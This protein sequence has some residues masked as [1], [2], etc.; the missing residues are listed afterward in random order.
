MLSGFLLVRLFFS[1]YNVCNDGDAMLCFS[2]VCF[3]STLSFGSV[4]CLLVSCFCLWFLFV[5]VCISEWL[6]RVLSKKTIYGYMLLVCLFS[7]LQN[8]LEC[9]GNSV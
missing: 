1:F 5:L 2:L 7:P 6:C 9:F 3:F 4:H 8:R